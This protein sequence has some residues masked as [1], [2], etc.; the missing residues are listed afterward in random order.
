MVAYF[1]RLGV[2]VSLIWRSC[3]LVTVCLLAILVCSSI[4]GANASARRPA[5]LTLDSESIPQFSS[6]PDRIVHEGYFDLQWKLPSEEELAE[7][8]SIA[9]W[10]YTLEMANHSSFS[11]VKVAYVGSDQG[12]YFSGLSD[13]D[14]FFRVRARTE[15]LPWSNW[16]H[17]HHVQVEHHALNFAWWLFAAGVIIFFSI[18]IFLIRVI[19]RTG[20]S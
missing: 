1:N 3:S 7:D 2:V 5:D 14:Y 16:S 12:T 15:S 19:N 6:D 8:K 11:D 13:G 17:V 10:Q 20:E 18:C 9:K 4:Y